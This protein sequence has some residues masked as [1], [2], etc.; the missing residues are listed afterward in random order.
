[1]PAYLNKMVTRKGGARRKTRHLLT[2]NYRNKGKMSLKAYFRQ[3][4]TGERVIIKPEPA[5]QNGSC[6]RRYFGKNA[7]V[8][9][10]QGD[11]Y[12][13]TLNVNRKQKKLIMHPVHLK[14]AL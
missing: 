11:C 14:K 3:F 2:K 12:E 10:K 13:V 9:K 4:E 5:H 8:S 1:M 7:L 6:H